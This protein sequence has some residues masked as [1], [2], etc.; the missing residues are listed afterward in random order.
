MM[1][2]EVK[3]GGGLQQ[4]IVLAGGPG[5]YVDNSGA[6]AP[7][8]VMNTN[9]SSATC[10]KAG[11]TGARPAAAHRRRPGGPVPDPGIFNPEAA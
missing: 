3:Q 10:E 4:L 6:S 2:G 11:H 9:T 5:W 1:L 8:R 7:V